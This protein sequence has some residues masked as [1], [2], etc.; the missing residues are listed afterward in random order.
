MRDP[1]DLDVLS[2]GA[3]P[4]RLGALPVALLVAAVVIALDQLT[5]WWALETLT[6][7]SCR[8]PDACIDLVAGVRF[9]LVFNTGAAFTTG[10]G[11][12][13]LLA[14]LAMALTTVLL[15]LAARQRSRLMVILFGAIAGGAMGN[16]ADRI[17]RAD[18]GLFSGAVVD[19]IDVGWWP[20]FNVADSAIVVGVVLV[21]IRTILTPDEEPDDTGPQPGDD[22][23]RDTASGGD[24]GEPADAR[25]GDEATEDVALSER[26][27]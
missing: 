24:Q 25:A 9:R 6:P 18:D 3:P 19:F 15:V 20:V 5:K 16:L 13:P 11:L 8:Q 12:G 26:P 14:I 22:D 21:M 10:S 23:G 27:E 4:F 7:G 17:F 1:Q 2:E